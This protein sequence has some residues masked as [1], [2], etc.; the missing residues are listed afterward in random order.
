MSDE[1]FIFHGGCWDCPHLV[2]EAI[3]S[4]TLKVKCEIMPEI[5]GMY[6]EALAYGVTP[7]GCPLIRERGKA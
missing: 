4:R 3:G 5:H 2:R 6:S 1:G 7:D